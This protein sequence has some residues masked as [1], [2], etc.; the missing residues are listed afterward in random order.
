M[1]CLGELEI[2]SCPNIIIGWGPWIQ[3]EG[4]PPGMVICSREGIDLR[5]LR[6]LVAAQ[7]VTVEV[8]GQETSPRFV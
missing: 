1:G 6:G 3:I 2:P 8:A 7:L 5:P 4:I